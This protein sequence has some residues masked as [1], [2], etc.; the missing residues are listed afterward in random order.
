MDTW[1]TSRINGELDTCKLPTYL[2]KAEVKL[3]YIIISRKDFNIKVNVRSP[4]S[5]NVCHGLKSAAYAVSV[6][7]SPDTGLNL[8]CEFAQ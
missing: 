1:T 2:A 4:R 7:V 5:T 6:V 8:P 3:S